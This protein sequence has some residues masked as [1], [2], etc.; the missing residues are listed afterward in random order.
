[1]WAYAGGG[2]TVLCLV[3]DEAH[4]AKQEPGVP[5]VTSPARV[6]AYLCQTP[7]R[8]WMTMVPERIRA[9]LDELMLQRYQRMCVDLVA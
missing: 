6:D 7:G 3:K 1:M 2:Q 8:W 4:R 9:G 5:V